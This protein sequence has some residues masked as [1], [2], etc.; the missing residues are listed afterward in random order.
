VKRWLPRLTLGSLA[1]FAVVAACTLLFAFDPLPL[2]SMRNAVFDL[3]QRLSPRP[4]EP[5]PVRVIDFG[6]E[7]LKRV[8]QWPWPRTTIA[9]LIRKLHEAGAVSIGFDVVFA[10]ADRTSP[11]AM[12]GTWRSTGDVRERLLALPDHDETLAGILSQSRVV[13]GF[14]ADNS[15]AGKSRLPAQHYRV[16]NAGDPA[17]PHLHAWSGAVTSLEALEKAASGAGSLSFFPDADGVVR[18]V[19]LL[20]NINGKV[21]PSLAAEV[22]RVGMNQRN[23]TVKTTAARVGPLEFHSGVAELRVGPLVVPTTSR[24]EF[25]VHYTNTRNDK[26]RETIQRQRTIEAWE[27][28]EGRLKPGALEGHVVLVGTSAQ[29]LMDLRASPM[30]GIMAGVEAHAQALEQILTKKFLERPYWTVMLETAILFLGGMLV[31]VVALSTRA[32]VG[33]GATVVMLV[34]LGA[35][36]W[37]AF[38]RH[39]LLFDPVTPGLTML[40]TFIVGGVIKHVSSEREQRWVREAF[41]RYVSPN[42][43]EYLVNNPGQLELGG[44]L[45]ECSFVFTDLEGFTTLIEAVGPTVAVELLNEY[46][47]RMVAI[48]FDHGG[49]LDRIVGDAVAI[50]F[51]APVPQPDHRER[52]FKCGL[53]MHE[54]A[55]RYTAELQAR[56]QRFGRTRVGVHTGEVLVGNFGGSTMF[57]YRALGDAVNTCSRLEGA[58]KYLGTTV[59]VSEETLA[60]CANHVARPIG[61]LVVKGKTRPLAVFDPLTEA[62]GAPLHERDAPYEAAYA[63]MKQGQGAEALA[64]FERL[65]HERPED[66]LVALQLERLREGAKDDFIKLDEK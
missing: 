30:G 10:E 65:W 33:A 14:A 31:G 8:G 42:R 13:L 25:W 47:D 22:L 38:T 62:R 1:T 34:L 59:C 39:G 28:L 36:G 58:N 64:A 35:A 3:Y 43:V 5:A 37:I 57:D 45:Q 27:V 23:Y 54:Y 32:L 55:S 6:D 60:G 50:M 44:R 12:V 24:G 21:M 52:A 63:L 41:S 61:Q 66:G 56:G 18:R 11:K 20:I 15:S 16:I 26:E 4:Y 49:T 40:L 19:P 29:G 46:L 51:S 53:A 2:Q 48:A 17:L 9:E 7:S